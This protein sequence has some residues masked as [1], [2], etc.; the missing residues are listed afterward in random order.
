MWDMPYRV[1]SASLILRILRILNKR[2]KLTGDEH[3][4]YLNQE[5]GFQ[6][7]VQF[8]KLT[9]KLKRSCHILNDLQ[10]ESNKS[11]FQ[12]DSS[13]IFQETYSLFE[14]KNFEGEYVYDNDYF[15]TLSGR[16]ILKPARPA[17]TK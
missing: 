2:M 10:L 3:W 8:D 6:G 17:K 12:L 16:D 9:E 13:L 7:E 4:Y 5:K 1:R 14:V 15:K 11:S